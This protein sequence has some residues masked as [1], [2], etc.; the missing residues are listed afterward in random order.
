[1]SGYFVI[2]FNEKADQPYHLI[3]KGANNETVLH[4]ENYEDERSAYAAITFLGALFGQK[5]YLFDSEAHY[6]TG[7]VEIRKVASGE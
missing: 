1:M 2:E 6:D 4:G 5:I 7:V 3:V